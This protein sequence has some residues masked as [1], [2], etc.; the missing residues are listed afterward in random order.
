[1]GDSLLVKQMYNG[2]CVSIILAERQKKRW[3][4]LLKKWLKEGM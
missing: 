3:N 1:M 4:E 2:D